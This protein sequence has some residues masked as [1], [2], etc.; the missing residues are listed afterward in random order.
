[1]AAMQV[2]ASRH[3][4]RSSVVPFAV[5]AFVGTVLLAGGLFLGWLAFATPVV[6]DLSP[7]A[8]QP[9]PIQLA[10]GGLVWGVTL[11]A[12]PLFA[13]VG[14]FRLGLVIHTVTARPQKRA[15]TQAAA[16]LGDE[17]I[18]ASN[19]RLPDG[20]SIRDIVLGPYGLAVVTELPPPRALRRS[21]ASWEIRR[22][23]GRWAPLENPLE[24]AARDAERLRSWAASEDRDF[25]VK[26]Y[27]AVVTTDPTVART[28]TCAV[29]APDQVPAWLSSLPASRG[30]NPDR[31]ADLVDRL[32]ALA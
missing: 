9:D 6:S 17:Y 25:L 16:H 18:S 5:G 14:L 30:L 23:D 12:P 10:F 26:T 4:P 24:R 21:G 32:S 31:R 13:I 3:A 8:I 20:R 19:I 22:P 7:R 1:M 28:A 27:A 2:I 11:V 15:V 29:I